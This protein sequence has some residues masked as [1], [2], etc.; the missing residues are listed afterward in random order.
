MTW[1]FR[2]TR[3]EKAFGRSGA[4]DL[5]RRSLEHSAYLLSPARCEG[6]WSR[7][8]GARADQQ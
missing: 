8:R 7:G 1:H 2:Y 6:D 3:P 5:V 4:L